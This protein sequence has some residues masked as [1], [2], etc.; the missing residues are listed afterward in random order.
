LQIARSKADP[1]S[2]VGPLSFHALTSAATVTGVS[3]PVRVAIDVGPLV[4]R[5]TGIGQAVAAM[6]DA[7]AELPDG[8]TLEP[9][10]LSARAELSSG[11]RRL[12]YP[13]ALAHRMW[14]RGSRPKADRR[15]RRPDV[16]HGTNY[17]VPP[18][19]CP[20]L[21]TV[22]DCWFL[23]HP[24]QVH[25][26]I[27]RSGAV[28]R[29][30]VATGATVH[31][32]SE[33][34]ALRVREL[35]GAER[36]VTIPLGPLPVAEI[37][38]ATPAPSPLT[39]GAPFVLAVGTMERRKN[40]PRLIAAFASAGSELGDHRLV[41]AGAPGDDSD[42][43]AAAIAQLDP[44]V[45]ARIVTLGWIDEETRSW[46]LRNASVLAYP[47]LDEGFGFPVLDAM[48]VGLPVVA[49]NA[50]SIP[51]VAGDAALLVAADDIDALAGALVAAVANSELRATMMERGHER[52]AA[53]SWQTTAQR[54]AQLYND[55]TES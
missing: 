37:S 30:S 32:S 16:I 39:D 21:V 46:L 8:P 47:S 1:H 7:L 35:L 41:L 51:E 5:R 50:G 9:Y 18:A 12:P 14:S 44:E 22:Y 19:V 38:A 2:A 25:P 33:A 4:A 15:L 24:D 28:L 11:T 54:L 3:R 52:V 48:S 23:L 31:A 43:T 53:H 36:V 20:R 55:L 29:R 27:A 13:A 17:V 40:L 45:A 26:D 34:T 49:S 6:V 10:V 42:A